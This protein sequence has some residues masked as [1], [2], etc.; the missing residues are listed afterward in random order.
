MLAEARNNAILDAAPDAIITIDPEGIVRSFNR[1]AEEIFGYT[2]EEM[3]LEP[4]HRLIAEEDMERHFADLALL[5]VGESTRLY[6]QFKDVR[7][8]HKDR[9]DI[10]VEAMVSRI[11][12]GG[13]QLFI[14]I[15]RDL[16]ERK[17]VERML[18]EAKEAAEAADRTKTAFRATVTSALRTPLHSIIGASQIIEMQS[19]GPVGSERYLEQ[20]ATIRHASR[21]L[22]AVI[23]DIL[24][25][26][27]IEAGS[28]RLADAVLDANEIARQ[29][30]AM[31]EATADDAGVNLSQERGTSLPRVRGDA[32]RLRQVLLNLLSNAIR[33]TMPGGD[34]TIALRTTDAGELAFDV[35]D[36]GVGM[37]PDQASGAAGAFAQ[38]DDNGNMRGGRRASAGAGLGLTLSRRLVE[39]HGGRLE[40]DSRIGQGTTVTVI[41]PPSVH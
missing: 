39:L 38:F 13:Q 20:A 36:T 29:S 30:V 31:V 18:V 10:F 17:R 1:T 15:L 4:I 16:S 2:A 12:V 37:T 5:K 3:L 32:L 22:L 19:H 33:F 34:I 11:D 27:A 24:D 40:I 8:L 41:L 35:R 28:L 6:S 7:L 26:T 9:S 21:S 14:G 25:I 23:D